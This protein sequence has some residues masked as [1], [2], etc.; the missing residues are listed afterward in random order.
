MALVH[1]SSPT[2][3]MTGWPCSFHA[4]TAC[5]EDAALHLARHFGQVAVAADEGAAEIGA[6]GNV[7]PPHVLRTRRRE[8]APSPSAAPLRAAASRCCRVRARAT[9]RRIPSRSRPAFMQLAK[10]AAPAPK[11]VTLCRATKRHST[12]QSG[13]S[14]L[15][16]R[17]AV[18]DA[19]G[20]AEEPGPTAASSTSPSRWSCTSGSARRSCWRHS[21]RPRRCAGRRRACLRMMPPWPC[22]MGL[23]RPV[24]PLE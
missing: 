2:S 8:S 6:A 12:L 21:S 9:G 3:P 16:R 11:K 1:T 7:A 14:L 17:V 22:T 19:E 23:G 10:K 24:V 20:G 5:A 4:S 15:R 18:V 13:F